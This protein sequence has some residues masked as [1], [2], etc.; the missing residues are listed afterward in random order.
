MDED[1]P[2]PRVRA[3]SHGP[4]LVKLTSPEVCVGF[5]RITFTTEEALRVLNWL[6]FDRRRAGAAPDGDEALALSAGEADLGEL[7]TLSQSDVESIRATLTTVQIVVAGLNE[8]VTVLEES[9]A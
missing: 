2:C 5:L 9:H 8:Q 4:V 6:G 3:V 1:I 7:S